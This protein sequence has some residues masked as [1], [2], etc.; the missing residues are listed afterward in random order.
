MGLAGP[1]AVTD[2]DWWEGSEDRYAWD[3]HACGRQ[4][5]PGP[6]A[7]HWHGCPNQWPG[8]LPS[9]RPYLWA[10]QAAR[11]RKTGASPPRE[12]VERRAWLTFAHLARLTEGV[13]E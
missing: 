9:Y 10:Y 4:T 13:R 7:R 8:A 2:A 12:P 11:V 3:C 6:I 5:P 1:W